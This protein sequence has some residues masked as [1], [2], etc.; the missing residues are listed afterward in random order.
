MVRLLAT[1]GISYQNNPTATR[2][3]DFLLWI[4]IFIQNIFVQ[5]WL[6]ENIFMYGNKPNY[7]I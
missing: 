1:Y 2:R 6:H 7:G 5:N 4:K 3:V